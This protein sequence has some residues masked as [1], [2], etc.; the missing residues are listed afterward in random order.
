MPAGQPA[1]EV[2]NRS[3]AFSLSTDDL[4]SS[5]LR[6]NVTNGGVHSK[7]FHASTFVNDIIVRVRSIVKQL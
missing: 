2:H 5:V 3:I 7:K 4:C 1:Q 6:P